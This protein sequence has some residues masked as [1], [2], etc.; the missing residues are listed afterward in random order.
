MRDHARVGFDCEF[1]LLVAFLEP[2]P[3]ELCWG[4]AGHRRELIPLIVAVVDQRGSQMHQ[5][6]RLRDVLPVLLTDAELNERRVLDQP[7]MLAPQKARMCAVVRARC[8]SAK[9]T[10]AMQP[11]RAIIVSQRPDTSMPHGMLWIRDHPAMMILC[12]CTDNSP[13]EAPTCQ[14]CT[15]STGRSSCC[16][17]W[18]G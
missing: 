10:K 9:A 12:R 7:R 15:Q 13:V 4:G 5:A 11:D 1:D 17:P 8:H 18:A 2:Q 6:G 3:V 14:P 16:R